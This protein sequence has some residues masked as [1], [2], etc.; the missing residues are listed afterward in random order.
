MLKLGTVSVK[1][2]DQFIPMHSMVF[3]RVN[4]EMEVLKRCCWTE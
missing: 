4:V 2:A 3:G 1:L